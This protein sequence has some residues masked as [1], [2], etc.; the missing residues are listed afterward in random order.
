[1]Y[2]VRAAIFDTDGVI[3]D[4][5]AVHERAWRDAFEELLERRG[6][7][8]RGLT[9]EDY[10]EHLDGRSRL[11]GTR[12]FLSSRGVELPDGAPEDAP[13]DGSLWAVGNAKNERFLTALRSDGVEVYSSTVALLVELRDRQVPTAAISAS[14]NCA[15]VLAAAGVEHLFDARV[16]GVV[17][18]E[19]SLEGKPDPAVFLEAAR[20][21]GVDPARTA[22]VEDSRAGVDAGRRGGFRPVVGIDRDGHGDELVSRGADLVVTDLSELTVDSE[23]TWSA[24]AHGRG[25]R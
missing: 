22:V 25:G 1:M 8:G 20:R 4:T 12:S 7:R 15:E 24:V 10:L 18:A 14:R 13:G 9:H 19:L 23:G 6:V 2:E 11:D 5:A 3:T 21:L 16:D 17:A